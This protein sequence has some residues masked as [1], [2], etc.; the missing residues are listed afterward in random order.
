MYAKV[1]VIAQSQAD[2]ERGFSDGKN[3]LTIRQTNMDLITFNNKRYVLDGISLFESLKDIPISTE[4]INAAKSARK[5]TKAR[6]NEAKN[7]MQDDRLLSSGRASNDKSK[8]EAVKNEL[9]SLKEQLKANLDA[10][11]KIFSDIAQNVAVMK[12]GK[13]TLASDVCYLQTLTDSTKKLHEK[14]EKLEK[15]IKDL[16]DKYEKKNI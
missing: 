7:K 6:R 16:E 8:R 14:R 3:M 12:P 9:N 11:K 4:L 13:K 5:N 10:E 15:M 1:I 2:V